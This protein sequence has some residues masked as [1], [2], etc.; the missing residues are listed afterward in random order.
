[1]SLSPYTDF[2]REEWSKLRNSTPLTLTEEDLANLRGI[3]ERI[4][5]RDV[6]DTYLPLS[7]LLNMYVAATQ[8][9]HEIGRAH[10]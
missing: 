8:S 3:N 10:V 7:R 5:L 1:M 4:S 6:E 2:T 9:L